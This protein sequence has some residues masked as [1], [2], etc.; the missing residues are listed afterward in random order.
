VRPVVRSLH[1]AADLARGSA[2]SH[3]RRLA[4]VAVLDRF[5][6]FAQVAPASELTG[7]LQLLAYDI[8]THRTVMISPEAAAVS[9]RGGVLCWSTGN[10]QPFLR[11]AL[12][13]RTV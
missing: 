8:T 12:D 3:H 1:R 10:Q 9:Y 13:L 7:R 2:S 11:H 6:A 5:E 4:D